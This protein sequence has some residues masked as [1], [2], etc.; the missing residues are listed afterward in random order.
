M[1][2]RI[3]GADGKT[4]GPV[5]LEQIRQWIAQ[6]RADSRTPVF[7]E[8]AADWTFLGLLPELAGDFA[9]TPPVVA[10]LKPAA[11]AA[12]GTNGFATAGLVCGLLAWTC[13]CSC[14]P[15]G[16]LGTIFS[17]IALVQTSSRTE[18]QEGRALAIIGL[19]LSASNLIFSLGFGL[20]QL[21]LHPGNV[22]WSVGR[23]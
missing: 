6:G 13:C 21:A 12:R 19:V 22:T 15:V 11:S 20:L 5:T 7:V 23:I 8:G 18:P 1:K 10:P 4:Y 17:I 3:V 14:F 2:Y 16:L 9:G